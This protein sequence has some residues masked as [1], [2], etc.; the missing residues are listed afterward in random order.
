MVT[1]SKPLNAVKPQGYCHR[2]KLCTVPYN[3]NLPTYNLAVPF[4]DNGTVED[5]LK[6][7]QN[8]QAVITGKN[9]MDPQKGVNRHQS[10]L[11]YKKTM[12]D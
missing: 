11:A 7:C 10:K 9:V 2:Y 5:W 6:F 12:E 1:F 4:Y 8:I 3:A